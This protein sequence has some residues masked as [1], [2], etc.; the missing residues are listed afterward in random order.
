MAH[1][2][3]VHAAFDDE[4]QMWVATS[5]DLTGL[6][7]EAPT[8]DGLVGKIGQVLPDLIEGNSITIHPGDTVEMSVASILP[9][10]HAA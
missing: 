7:V 10:L 2:F 5:E 6:V 1:K 3:S 9:M 8:L 4:A